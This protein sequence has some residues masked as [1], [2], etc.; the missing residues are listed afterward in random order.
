MGDAGIMF[1]F[2]EKSSFAGG[3]PSFPARPMPRAGKQALG[4]GGYGMNG[5]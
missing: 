3:N 1:K 4:G 5:A 2:D